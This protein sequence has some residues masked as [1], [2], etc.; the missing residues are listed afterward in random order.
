MTHVAASRPWL[1]TAFALALALAATLG[2]GDASAC[3]CEPQAGL[4]QP[5]SQTTAV[6]SNTRV[7]LRKKSFC[8]ETPTL[9][10][11]DGAAVAVTHAF[12]NQALVLSP[13]APLTPGTSYTVE[14]CT[15]VN[16][17]TFT[18]TEGPDTTPPPA[19]SVTPGQTRR[20]LA[21]GTC[22]GV[23][24]TEL[25]VPLPAENTML[26]LDVAGRAQPDPVKAL[27]LF[28][29]TDQPYVGYQLCQAN[30]NPTRS[31]EATAVRL[32]AFDLAG[33][34][35]DWSQPH[36]VTSLTEPGS[37]D[38]SVPRPAARPRDGLALAGLLPAL[39]WVA[40][41]RGQR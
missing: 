3:S 7:W 38:C 14:G 28:F 40:R 20:E 34:T 32:L 10:A 17:T 19:P 11:A 23:L 25:T 18:V 5:N 21:D 6:P 41:R 15:N 30:W 26:A 39:A 35:S 37:S 16:D 33:N 8:G 9:R 12:V 31:G 29:A 24:Y 36:D 22:G 27:D 2:A 1:A 4:M 13:T